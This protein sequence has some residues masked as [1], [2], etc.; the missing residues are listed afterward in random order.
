MKFEQLLKPGDSI[1]WVCDN[2]ECSWIDHL[3]LV[4][5]SVTRKV[6]FHNSY[7]NGVDFESYKILKCPKFYRKDGKLEELSQC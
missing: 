4:E 5:G 6:V 2:I 1:C 3:E 7:K